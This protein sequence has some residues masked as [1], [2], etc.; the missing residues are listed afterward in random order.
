MYDQLYSATVEVR[1]NY[2]HTHAFITFLNCIPYPDTNVSEIKHLR[3]TK[4]LHVPVVSK[5]FKNIPKSKVM[6]SHILLTV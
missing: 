1:S 4:L 6:R 3:K 2:I 5:L